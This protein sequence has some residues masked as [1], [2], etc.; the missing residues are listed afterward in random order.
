V[1]DAEIPKRG[2]TVLYTTEERWDMVTHARRLLS[3]E[4]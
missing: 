2:H 1:R 4:C 3:P